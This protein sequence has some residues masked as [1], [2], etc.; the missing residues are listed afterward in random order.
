M[1]LEIDLLFKICPPF[2]LLKVIHF[3]SNTIFFHP[4]YGNWQQKTKKNC[5]EMGNAAGMVDIFFKKSAI[6]NKC[7]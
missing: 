5:L 2:V 7:S 3:Y 1:C 6:G 4:C